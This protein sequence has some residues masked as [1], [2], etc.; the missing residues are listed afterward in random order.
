MNIALI[1]A[2]GR[3]KF[4]NLALMK[5]SA[6]H[7]ARGDRVQWWSTDLEHFD[8]VYMAKVFS[9]TYTPDHPEPLNAGQVIK[10]GTGYAIALEGGR[11]VYHPELDPP[12]P[13]EIEHIFP[14]YGLYPAFPDTACGFLTRGCPRGC[15]FCHVAPK[16]GRASRKA[17][18]LRE[19]WNG[20]RHIEVM[21]PNILACPER[22]DLLA[23]LAESG[24]RVNFNQGLDIRLTD[25]DTAALLGRMRGL[26][27]HFAW[28]NPREDLEPYLERFA[29]WYPRKSGKMVYILCGFW[30]TLEEDLHRIETVDRLGYDPYV[31]LYNKPGTPQILRD[32]QRWCNNK[33]IYK[34]TEDKKTEKKDFNQYL[35]KMGRVIP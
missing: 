30:S 5:I 7:K 3:G 24:A 8:A 1:D 34:S 27:L 25:R 19:F 18:D 28:D 14:D 22:D 23:Q 33:I 17:A 13:E 16:E 15:P 31:M 21:D 11:E 26:K 20:Q 2:D 12:L 35:R 10:G 4:P 32:L 6:W 9:D 29:R